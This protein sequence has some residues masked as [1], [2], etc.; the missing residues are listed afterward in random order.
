MVKQ[1]VKQ[2]VDYTPPNPTGRGGFKKGRSGN[3]NG[4]PKGSTVIERLLGGKEDLFEC[5]VR[6]RWRILN[7]LHNYY[8][9]V[10]S[11]E[12]FPDLLLKDHDGN[13]VRCEVETDSKHF[14]AHGHDINK[15]DLIIC[16]NHNW[17]DCPIPVFVVSVPWFNQLEADKVIPFRPKQMK[18]KL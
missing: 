16:W 3:P 6:E 17:R 15:C 11:Q 10:L 14:L 7:Y 4:R 5:E 8:E 2:V 18:L 1:P 9:V 12:G 13:L